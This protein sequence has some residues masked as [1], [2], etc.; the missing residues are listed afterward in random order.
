MSKKKN[1]VSWNE[2]LKDHTSRFSLTAMFAGAAFAILLAALLIVGAAALI[3]VNTGALS[4]GDGGLITFN[5]FMALMAL[6]LSIFGIAFSFI[7]G[8]LFMLPINTIINM[9]NRLARGEYKSRIEF[10]GFL[11]KNSSVSEMTNSINKMAEELE[12]TEVLRS[13]FV[14]N[15]S[16]E[17]KTPI[18]SIAGF[19]KLLK[20]D[21]LTEN[22]RKEYLDIIEEESRRLSVM[23]TNVLN[24]TKIENQ[25]ILTDISRFN[26]SEQIR[27]CVLILEKKWTEKNLDLQLDFNEFFVVGNDELL[28]Q[29]WL[30]LLDNAVK[31][32]PFGGT[33]SVRIGSDGNNVIVD[34]VNTGSSIPEK[35]RE[36]VFAKFYQCDT[37]HSTQGNGVG[38]AV[39][40]RIV[41]L[42]GGSVRVTSENDVTD[43]TVSLPQKQ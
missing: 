6:V 3:L 38:L 16:H 19:A 43:F 37:S 40:K 29:V 31:F 12:N 32:T 4:I 15:F 42:H 27:N 36:R 24:L 10:E 23:A 41:D 33:V 9:M 25:T 30:N 35:D 8:R 22:Q 28:R 34:V 14:N 17:F 18:V 7:F 20:T 1:A 11:S 13:D 26:L 39:V 21:G 2:K 5:Q